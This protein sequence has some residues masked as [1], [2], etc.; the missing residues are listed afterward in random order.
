MGDSK[1]SPGK[2]EKI[3][4]ESLALDLLA[5]LTHLQWKDLSLCG[6]SMGG[7]YAVQTSVCNPIS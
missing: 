7:L 4:I 3:T 5:L 6:F 2:D 1:L